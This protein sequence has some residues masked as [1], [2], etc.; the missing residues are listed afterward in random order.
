VTADESRFGRAESREIPTSGLTRRRLLG[1]GAG[2][3]AAVAGAA[4]V[5]ACGGSSGSHTTGQGAGASASAGAL[6]GGTPVRGGVFTLGMLT[7]GSEENLWPGASASNPDFCRN[8][9]LYNLLFYPGQRITPIVPGLA[10]SAESN[11]TATLW[12]FHLRDGVTWHDGKP[13]TA[14]DV[15][16]NFRTAWADPKNYAHGLLTGLAD[17]QGVRKVDRL[18]VQVPLHTASAEFPSLFTFQVFLIVQNGATQKSAAQK[19]IGTGPFKF[20]SFSPGSQ[21]TFVANK[22]YWEKDKPYVDKV[23]VDS[24]FNDNNSIFNALVSG[25]LNLA[26]SVPLVTARQQLSSR[27]VQILVSDFAAETYGFYW[28]VDKGPFVDNRVGLGFKLLVDRPAI[29]DGALA[30]LGTVAYDIP[31]AGSRYYAADLKRTQDVEQAKA[32]FKAAGVLGKTFTLATSDAFP[33]MIESATLLAQQAPA[34]GVK[35]AVQTQSA[36]TYYTTAGG[37][38]SRYFGQEE[39]S[40]LTSLT[41]TYRSALTLAAPYPDTHWGHQAGGAAAE[42]VITDAMA[43][44]DPTRAQA[45]WREAQLQQFNRGGFLWW[46]NAPY[47]DAAATGVRGLAAGAGFNYNC[48]RLLDGWLT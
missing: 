22:D 18:T 24:S 35:V 33:G 26:S 39:N 3:G 31:G 36:A 10:L 42:K 29:N 45:L 30:G 20:S 17:F 9:Q 23:V 13:F 32:M 34:A 5:S 11:K 15:V 19:P 6:P 44:T 27:Q 1:A 43:A 14:D 48:W 46:A 7:T 40:P 38:L 28:R 2:V 8:Y 16:Y 25:Q 21:S 47:V 4:L 37:W 41:A 12:T